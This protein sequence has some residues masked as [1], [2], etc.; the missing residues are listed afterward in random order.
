MLLLELNQSPA[1]T[2]S[3]TSLKGEL[4]SET[5]PPPAQLSL[6]AHRFQRSQKHWLPRMWWYQAQWHPLWFLCQIWWQK[7]RA[8]FHSSLSTTM[9]ITAASKDGDAGYCWFVSLLEVQPAKSSARRDIL[10]LASTDQ[11]GEGAAITGRML[12]SYLTATRDG[13]ARWSCSLS[14]LSLG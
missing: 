7:G 4:S 8:D 9:A 2:C 10:A 11:A 14:C 5:V 3:V 12:C 6:Q 1:T 13:A